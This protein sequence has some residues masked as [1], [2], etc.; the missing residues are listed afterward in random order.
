MSKYPTGYLK[1]SL[2][3]RSVAGAPVPSG[4][5]SSSKSIPENRSGESAGVR[6]DTIKTTGVNATKLSYIRQ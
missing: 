3:N 1:N 4:N 6:P 2:F 5:W